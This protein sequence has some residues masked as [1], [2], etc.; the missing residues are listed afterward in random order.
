MAS[1][2]LAYTNFEKNIDSIDEL[3]AIYKIIEEQLPLLQEQS[4]EIL[5]AIIVLSVSHLDNFLHDFYRSE[6]VEAYLG[7]GDFNVKFEKIK[8]SIK[9]MAEIDSSSSIPEKRNYLTNELRKIQKTDSYQSGKSIENL[10]ITLNIKNIWTQLEKAGVQGL[11]AND[12]KTEL[13]NIIDRRN[14][15]SHESDWDFINQKKYPIYL[16]DILYVVDFIKNFVKGINQ[17]K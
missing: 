10:F 3:I 1:N 9:G 15:I 6:I 17:I 5:R 4:S 14:K 12:I 2:N 7:T 11:K 13:A 8:I 16:N